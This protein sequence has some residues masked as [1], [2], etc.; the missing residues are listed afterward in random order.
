M[1]TLADKAERLLHICPPSDTTVLDFVRIFVHHAR[2]ARPNV[3]DQSITPAANVPKEQRS[4]ER[5]REAA[6]GFTFA[7]A[8]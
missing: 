8:S 5:K 3:T 1:A 7:D 4:L 6:W 2:E